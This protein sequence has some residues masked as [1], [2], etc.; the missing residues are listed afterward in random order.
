MMLSFHKDL[1]QNSVLF[2]LFDANLKTN[3][4]TKIT[5]QQE[6][7]MKMFIFWHSHPHKYHEQLVHGLI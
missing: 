5:P 6:I 1:M 3:Y 2:H 4:Q 7:Q